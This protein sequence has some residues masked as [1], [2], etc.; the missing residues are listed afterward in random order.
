MKTPKDVSA[1]YA[2]K[3]VEYRRFLHAHPELTNQERETSAWIKDK[4][5]E[6][7][8]LIRDGIS[9]NSVVGVID[10]ETGGPCI[11]FSRRYGCAADS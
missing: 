10:G 7:G 8:I 3:L 11:A 9:G 4:L 5:R 1:A 6:C 2:G